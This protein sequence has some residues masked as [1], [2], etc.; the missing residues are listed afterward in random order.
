MTLI[1]DEEI[2]WQPP[3]STTGGGVGAT[4]E[5]VDSK[6]VGSV[7]GEEIF[8]DFFLTVAMECFRTVAADKTDH[9][10]V[11]ITVF[12]HTVMAMERKNGAEKNLGAKHDKPCLGS[13]LAKSDKKPNQINVKGK[14]DNQDRKRDTM[15]PTAVPSP[16]THA[17]W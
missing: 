12:C 6:E 10:E 11:A 5:E 16:V 9:Q 14:P 3:S 1:E 7:T 15:N 4:P 2:T 17:S 13:C 8:G